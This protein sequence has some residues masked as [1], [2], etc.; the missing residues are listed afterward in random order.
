MAENCD[1]HVVHMPLSEEYRKKFNETAAQEFFFKTEGLPYGY[2]NFLY[3]WIDTPEDNYPLLLPQDL[4]TVVFSMLERITRNTTDI[5]YTEA[6]NFHLFGEDKHYNI[7]QIAAEGAKRGMNLTEIM[8]ISEQDG[9][10]YDGQYHDGFAYVCSSYVAALWKAA[11]LFG[12]DEINA[13]EWSP[14]DVY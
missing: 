1:F 10:K 3:A 9:W 2:H 13:T 12:D 11:G 8:A 5:F 14:K 7:S 6:L 4:V